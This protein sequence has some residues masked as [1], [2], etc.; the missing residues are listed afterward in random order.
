M[1]KEGSN[2][3]KE[4]AVETKTKLYDTADRLFTKHGIDMVSVDAIVE[5]AGVSKGAFYVHFES[6]DALIAAQISDYV[7]KVD[8]DYKAFVDAFSPDTL[9]ADILLSL[10]VRI[11]DIIIG[12]IGYERMRA[13]YKVQ[14]TGAGY[15]QAAASYNRT[16]YQLFGN[17]LEQGILRGE[18]KASLPVDETARHF[19]LALRGLTYEWCIRYPDF[20]LKE[21]A[22]THFELLM[23]GIANT[24]HAS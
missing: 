7:E 18:L 23:A 6:K 1:K 20:D 10:V 16:L 2:L 22:R 13:L 14:L 12:K 4:R 5:A 3:R 24:D 17:V 11:S 21:Q 19:I 8:T 15:A 9:T